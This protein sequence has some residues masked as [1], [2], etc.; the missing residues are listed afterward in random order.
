M[1]L[2]LRACPVFVA[3]LV[4]GASWW[5][6]S[7][8]PQWWQFVLSVAVVAAWALATFGARVGIP[9]LIERLYAAL[10]ALSVGGWIAAATALGPFVPPLPQGLAVGGLVLSVPWWAHRRRR[11]RVRVER[12]LEAWPEVAKAVGLAGSQV[13][14]AMVDVWRWR[15]R[16]RLARG[17]TIADVTARIPAIESGLGTF[18][19]AGASIRPGTTWPTGASF[20]C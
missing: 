15:A 10:A 19:G 7:A 4:L 1:A 18:R 16:L 14:S 13:M 9:A 8:H 12:K 2:P 20:A 17:Q 5:L 11:A 3:A 6:H